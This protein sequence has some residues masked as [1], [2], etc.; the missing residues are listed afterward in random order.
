V[1]A[2]TFTKQAE[3]VSTSVI[4][5]KT[6]DNCFL[7][8]K[9]VLMV[10]FMQQRTTIT[11]SETLKELLWVIR[12]KRLGMV[13][14]G[15]VLLHDNGLP[16]TAACTRT[17]LEHSNWELFDHPPYSPDLTPSNFHLL[18]YLKNCLVSQRFNNNEEMMKGVKTWLSSQTADFFDAGIQKLIPR[19]D[20]CLNFGDDHVKKQLQYV[21]VF[22]DI[23]ICFLSLLV[24]LIAHRKLFSEL[25]SYFSNAW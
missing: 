5:Q 13:T 15:V 14:S 18:T 11:Y 16:H 2:H 20:K 21:R 3:I 4:C 23:R 22:L 25:P 19:Y 9:G 12:N 1:D 8:Q 17:L 7:K 24:L 6:D 10:E